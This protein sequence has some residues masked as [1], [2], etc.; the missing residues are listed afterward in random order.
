MPAATRARH[1][2]QILLFDF[3]REHG[4]ADALAFGPMTWCQTLASRIVQE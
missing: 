3:Q 2:E 4:P 1:H